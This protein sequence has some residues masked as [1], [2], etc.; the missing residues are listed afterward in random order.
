[1][2]M[3][4]GSLATLAFASLAV[5]CNSYNLHRPQKTPLSAHCN[6][7][8]H[9]TFQDITFSV[10]KEDY[11]PKLEEHF[12]LI[13][14]VKAFGRKKLGFVKTPNYTHYRDGKRVPIQYLYQLF[15]SPPLS[16][17]LED[18]EEKMVNANGNHCQ[19]LKDS[20]KLVSWIDDFSDE[21][22]CYEEKGY[23]VYHRKITDYGDNSDITPES[24]DGLLPYFVA[25]ILH[26]DFHYTL[27]KIGKDDM[28]SALEESLA[29]FTGHMGAIEYFRTQ[30]T[31][32]QQ[33][34]SYGP[35]DR[36]YK[37]SLAINT[38]V[39]QLKELYS[40]KKKYSTEELKK[41]RDEI[42]AASSE[43]SDVNEAELMSQYPYTKNYPAIAKLYEY[44]DAKG[45]KDVSEKMMKIIYK[46]PDSEKDG[47]KYLQ[48][49]HPKK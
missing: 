5:G 12:K 23:H 44:F 19:D 11:T 45:Q 24:L 17:S 3:L 22:Q 13:A 15:V 2:D 10:C 6:E 1:M 42:F 4:R 41:K 32:S 29:T 18:Y 20:R 34:I 36:W 21:Q 26:E 9:P 8:L 43:L 40:H 28:D 35:M 25:T 27:D 16:S 31:T 48:A 33:F 37:F 49:L 39:A 14:D 30:P 7:V 47:S 46:T 38:A